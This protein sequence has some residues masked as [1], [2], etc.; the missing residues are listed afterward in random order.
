[1]R[2]VV[3]EISTIGMGR[4]ILYVGDLVQIYT[5]GILRQP[6]VLASIWRHRGAWQPSD[7]T[8]VSFCDAV[9]EPG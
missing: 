1:M 6:G 2:N 4:K 3:M 5:V 8:M 9:M 7:S